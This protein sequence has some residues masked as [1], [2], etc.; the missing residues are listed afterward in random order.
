[1]NTCVKITNFQQTGLTEKGSNFKRYKPGKPGAKPLKMHTV[2]YAD[3]ESILVSHSTCD[4]KHETCK[5]VNKQV[6]CGYS[7]NVYTYKVYIEKH[8][9]NIVIAV[10]MLLVIFVKKCVILHMIL[11]IF[12][13]NL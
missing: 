2:I 6:P 11:L 8:Q 10:K 4:K 3:F 5:K 1:M 12:T 13:N 9:S 7:I